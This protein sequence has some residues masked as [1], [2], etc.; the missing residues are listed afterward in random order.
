MRRA[1]YLAATLAAVAVAGQAGAL[2]ERPGYS[3][4]APGK[5]WEQTDSINGGPGPLETWT[6]VRKDGVNA[7]LEIQRAGWG[8]GSETLEDY[9]RQYAFAPRSD[10]EANHATFTATTINGASCV[11]SQ[12]TDSG[13]DATPHF[14]TFVRQICTHPELPSFAVQ[15]RYEFGDV[16]DDI[17]AELKAIAASLRFKP[18]PLRLRE[19]RPDCTVTTMVAAEGAVWASC[20]T[21]SNETNRGYLV[22][23]DPVSGALTRYAVGRQCRELAAV[24][25][26]VWLTNLHDKTV[27]RFD[28]RSNHVTATIWFPETPLKLMAAGGTLWVETDNF[29]SLTTAFTQIDPAKATIMRNVRFDT[30]LSAVGIGEGVLLQYFKGGEMILLDGR[31]GTISHPYR[32]LSRALSATSFDGEQVWLVQS[33][34]FGINAP[35]DVFKLDPRAPEPGPVLVRRVPSDVADAVMWK[36]MF[37]ALSH[38]A[39]R[40]FRDEM[41]LEVPL[42]AHSPSHLFSYAG[43]LWVEDFASQ[44]VIRIDPK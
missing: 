13:P 6:F 28:P 33:T 35:A 3:A 32:R 36:G 41:V 1:I 30:N 43:S 29:R 12:S 2:L 40:C 27:S 7:K 8:V 39:V 11:L 10:Y 21:G 19:Y 31:T 5:D 17:G 16:A 14:M 44:A 24:G 23:I 38:D 20:E 34:G 9:A 37:C 25:G 22:R 18:I 4:Q 42:P 15:I 26:Y